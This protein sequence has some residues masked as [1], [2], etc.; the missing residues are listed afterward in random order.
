MSHLLHSAKIAAGMT[1]KRTAFTGPLWVQIGL[2]NPCNHRCVMCWDHPTHVPEDSPFPTVASAK[3]YEDHPEI[4]RDK[5]FFDLG[6]LEDLADDLRAMGTKRVELVGRGEPTMHPKFERCVEILKERD[7]HVGIATNGSLLHEQ[8]AE[9]MVQLGLNRIVLSLNAGTRETYPSIH[10]T[11]TPENFDKVLRNLA[12]LRRI[13]EKHGKEDPRVM[14]SFVIS[15]PNRHEAFDMLERAR[16]IGADQVL[17]KFAIA[18]PGIEFIELDEEEKRAFSGR[19]GEYVERA[20]SYGID[21]KVEP[22]IGDMTADRRLYHNKTE[23]V[24]SKIPCYIGWYFA[25]V[26]AEGSV[27]PCCQCMDQMGHL[28]TQRFKDVW[29]SDRYAEFREQQKTFPERMAKGIKTAAQCACDECAFEK[30]NTTVYNTLHFYNPVHLHDAQREFTLTQLL[31][32]VLTGK[33][34]RGA[35]AVKGE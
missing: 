27:S 9:R 15:R 4:D 2:T 17:F 35:K 32:A 16:E 22:P 12:N 29:F 7:L 11:E 20:R 1:T 5:G 24:Y 31:P 30:V 8:R 34:T 33:T 21:L 25:L 6:M 10:T 18:Y 23:T 28:K 26:T 14:V 13:K 3:F 19:L